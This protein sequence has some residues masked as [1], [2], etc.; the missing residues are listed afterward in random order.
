[1]TLYIDSAYPNDITMQC[2]QYLLLEVLR[3]LRAFS[4]Q[5]T[6]HF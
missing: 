5:K 1:M 6:Q 2:K 4:P 3:F